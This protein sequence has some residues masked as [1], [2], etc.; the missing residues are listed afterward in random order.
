MA[1]TLQSEDTS[2]K[3][4]QGDTRRYEYYYGNKWMLLV[5]IGVVDHCCEDNQ[6]KENV[7]KNL[8]LIR[9]GKEICSI[10]VAKFYAL[11]SLH[12]NIVVTHLFIYNPESL[13]KETALPEN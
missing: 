9:K 8:T 11:K 6:I 1:W 4:L 3:L 7:K 2:V 10:D 13:Y 12:W 5:C